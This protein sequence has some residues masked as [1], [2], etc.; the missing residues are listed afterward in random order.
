[1]TEDAQFKLRLPLDLKEFI[2]AE[3]KANYRT[4]NGE[5]LYRL[6]Q[7]RQ[8]SKTFYRITNYNGLDEPA[9]TLEIGPVT[10]GLVKSQYHEIKLQ[11]HNQEWYLSYHALRAMINDELAQKLIQM[12]CD[13]IEN[14]KA[15]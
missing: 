8:T 7:G 1:M 9:M 6:E 12:G 14:K 4:I 5:V 11:R 10:I 13:L 15:P 2:E 3:A